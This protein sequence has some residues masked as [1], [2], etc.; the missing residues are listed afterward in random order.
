MK[1]LLTAFFA[2]AGIAQAAETE[3]AF[4]FELKPGAIEEECVELAKGEK[5]DFRW[6]ADAPVDFNI[7]YHRGKH[8]FFPVKDDGASAGNGTFTAQSAEHYCWMWSARERAV[9]VE[10]RIR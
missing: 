2:L 1:S 6:K 4:A 9:K 5:R 7:H 3:K 8:V 10:G